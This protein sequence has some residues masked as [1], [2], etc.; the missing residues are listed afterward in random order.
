MSW[1]TFFMLQDT[2]CMSQD[3]FDMNLVVATVKHENEVEWFAG[4]SET[5]FQLPSQLQ[6]CLYSSSKLAVFELFGQWRKKFWK[7]QPCFRLVLCD[8]AN[9]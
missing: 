9:Y 6:H 4:K 8:K 2:S 7:N 1:N 3:T 5:P